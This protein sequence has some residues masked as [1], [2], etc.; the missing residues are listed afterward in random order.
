[1]WDPV[2]YQVDYT[3]IGNASTA[4]KAVIIVKS[5]GDKL[6]LVEKH[7]PGSYSTMFTNLARS[8]DVG[9]HTVSYTVKLKNGATLVDTDTDTSQITVYP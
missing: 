4:Y 3:I 5:M 1:V 2:M 7:K 9:T 8:D 6:R